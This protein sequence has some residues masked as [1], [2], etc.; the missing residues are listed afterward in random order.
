MSEPTD[1]K[2]VRLPDHRK[3]FIKRIRTE[4]GNAAARDTF[5]MMVGVMR[6][7]HFC[8]ENLRPTVRQIAD[9]F[10]IALPR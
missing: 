5:F 7:F 8:P 3:K 10:G 6:T 2:I 1:I 4:F 9:G